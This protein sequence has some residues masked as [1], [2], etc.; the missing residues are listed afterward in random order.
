MKNYFLTQNYEQNNHPINFEDLID[1][2]EGVFN[3]F[4]LMR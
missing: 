2:L 1:L 3:H 4:E